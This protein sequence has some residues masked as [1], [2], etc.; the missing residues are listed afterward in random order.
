[1]IETGVLDIITVSKVSKEKDFIIVGCALDV[2]KPLMLEK[3][4]SRK[5]F[6]LYKY[7]HSETSLHQKY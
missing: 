4:P 2:R 5:D 1:L 7:F 3:K 6:H